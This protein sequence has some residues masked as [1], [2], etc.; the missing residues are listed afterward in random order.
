LTDGGA[1]LDKV[2]AIGPRE[3]NAIEEREAER[4]AG[5]ILK[6]L[7]TDRQSRE[8]FIKNGGELAKKM[9]WEVVSR[10]YLLPALN[11]LR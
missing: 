2:L 9:S 4:I 11:E 1:T 6:R 3:R 7:P 10:D 8:A 5:E